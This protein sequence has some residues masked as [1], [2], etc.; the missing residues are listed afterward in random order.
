MLTPVPFELGRLRAHDEANRPQTR[1]RRLLREALPVNMTYSYRLLH[2]SLSPALPSALLPDL[3]F[4]SA[5]IS[6]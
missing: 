3:D 6:V 5:C 1:S 4:G 2:L